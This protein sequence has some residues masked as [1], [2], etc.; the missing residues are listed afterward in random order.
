MDPVR[1][2]AVSDEHLLLTA[3]HRGRARSADLRVEA[4]ILF[5]MRIVDGLFTSWHMYLSEEDALRGAAE[6][7][8]DTDDDRPAERD[9]GERAQE[10]GPEELRADHR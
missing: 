2:R 3:I 5:L 1:I 7:R 9:G 6:R 8:G 10:A 4:E